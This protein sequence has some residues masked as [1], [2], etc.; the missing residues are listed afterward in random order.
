ML[1][2]LVVI[3][4]N[5]DNIPFVASCEYVTSS[6]TIASRLVNNLSEPS[7]PN[8][9]RILSLI[10]TC[11]LLETLYD[12]YLSYRKSLGNQAIEL[13]KINYQPALL[14]AEVIPFIYGRLH[15]KKMVHGINT[16]VW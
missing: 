1:K 7:L 13:S 6:L 5:L 9:K 11:L 12:P 2:S 8:E 10:L 4:R 16:T 15:F 3:G 14:Q